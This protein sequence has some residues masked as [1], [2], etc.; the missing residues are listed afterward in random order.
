MKEKCVDFF[1]V[2]PVY[3]MLYFFRNLFISGKVGE[4]FHNFFYYVL[5]KI[6]VT[7][8][9]H[10]RKFQLLLF[11]IRN[12][13]DVYDE[14]IRRIYTASFAYRKHIIKNIIARRL[15][16]G[17][18]KRHFLKWRGHIVPSVI[19][20]SLNAPGK[21]CNLSCTQCYANTHPD[22]E[23]PFETFEKIVRQQEQL[24]IYCVSILGGEPF[25]YKGIYEIF[26]KYP[27]T[28]FYVSTN[29]TVLAYKDLKRIASLGNVCLFIAMEGFEDK[30]K[31]IRGKGVFEKVISIMRFCKMEKIIFFINV[32][33]TR[34]NFDEVLG[35]KFLKM[36][37]SL[38]CF[39]ANYSC[40]LPLGKM[41]QKELELTERQAKHLEKIAGRIRNE[42]PFFLTIGRNGRNVS[43]C[44][45]ANQYI[46][47]LPDGRVEPCPFAHWASDKYNVKKNSILEITSSKFFSGIRHLN[48]LGVSGFAP[49]QTYNSSFFENIYRKLGAIAT[50]KGG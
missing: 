46:H 18:I 5:S 16:F 9:E 17:S 4:V 3:L 45:A 1:I 31:S 50:A 20:I 37:D 15:I 36:I 41:N 34:S 22:C 13:K 32:T 47:I 21:G 35:D 2:E 48:N 6:I 12:N 19:S 40:Y 29:G 28:T 11:S 25:M 44:F 42:Y 14:R 10:R 24:G 23:M 49:C 38:G 8:T 33:L 7:Q 43:N 39:G 27:N 26:K 30:T